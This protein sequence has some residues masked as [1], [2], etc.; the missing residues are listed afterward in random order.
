MRPTLMTSSGLQALFL[1][2]REKLL[3]FLGAHGAGDAAEDLLQ[4]LWIRI[5][6]TAPR[7]PIAAPLSYLYRAANNLMVDRHR[8]LRQ[9]AVR[10]QDWSDVFGAT[11]P[12]KS[13]EPSGERTLL[14]REALNVAQATLA[15]APPRAVAIFCRHRIDGVGQKDIAAEMGLSLSTVESDLRIVYRALLE[16]RRRIDE[17]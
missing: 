3:R 16:A 1:A 14:A 15:E 12:G 10:E 6:T 4:E 11:V 2:N 13:D 8:S 7:G 9:A 17:A 5:S